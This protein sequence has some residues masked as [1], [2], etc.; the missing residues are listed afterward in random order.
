MT[1]DLEGL[2]QI[3]I[4]YLRELDDATERKRRADRSRRAARYGGAC[5]SAAVRRAPR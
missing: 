2:W 5:F 1:E 3:A 4:D